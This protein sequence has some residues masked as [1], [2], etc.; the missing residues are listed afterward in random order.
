M[1][2]SFIIPVYNAEKYLAKCVG[3]IFSQNLHSN[4]FEVIA[5]NDGSE[6]GSLKML[7]TLQRDYDNI[8]ILNTDNAGAGA[9]RNRGLKS[10]TGTVITF[11]DADDF[12]EPECICNLLDIFEKN[13]LEI[14][15]FET[16]SVRNKRTIITTSLADGYNAI[17]TGEE[18]LPI[19]LNGF[20]PCAKLY[21][22]NL[23]FDNLLFFPEGVIPEDIG[24]I[25]KLILAANR[26]MASDI[27]GYHYNYNPNSV[28]KKHSKENFYL[29]IDGLLYV[30]KSLNEFSSKYSKSNFQVYNYI[31]KDIIDKVILELFHFIEYRTHV[32]REKLKAIFYELKSSNLLPL[33]SDNQNNDKDYLFNHQTLFAFCYFFRTKQIYYKARSA[34]IRLKRIAELFFNK[35]NIRWH[36]VKRR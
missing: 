9:A 7:Q 34:A 5:V 16:I 29:R 36:E 30:A 27:A 17:F 18:F 1:K 21:K 33:K 6:D 35:Y 24:L 23:F 28:T 10:S 22:R 20:G 31:Q 2:I 25:P 4:D 12:L 19:Y 11:V 15:L 3:S 32:K 14:L 13:K 8:R 26:V